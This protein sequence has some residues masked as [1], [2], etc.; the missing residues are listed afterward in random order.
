MMLRFSSDAPRRSKYTWAAPGEEAEMLGETHGNGG[1]IEALG[2]DAIDELLG[3]I[4]GDGGNGA[5][6][7]GGDNDEEVAASAITTL[8][9]RPSA[10]KCCS[11]PPGKWP[12]S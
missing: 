9:T 8:T 4:K 3:R 11:T 10:S 5:G 1:Q 6:N 7:N 2:G 12:R